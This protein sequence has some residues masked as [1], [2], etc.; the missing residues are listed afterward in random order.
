MVHENHSKLRYAWNKDSYGGGR[1]ACN[2]I[3]GE[4]TSIESPMLD[5]ILNTP[6]YGFFYV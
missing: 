6:T 1:I 5:L 4:T 2:K 3:K